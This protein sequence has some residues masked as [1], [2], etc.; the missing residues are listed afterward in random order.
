[1]ICC[2]VGDAIFTNSMTMT[3]TKW[4]FFGLTKAFEFTR[5]AQIPKF[6]CFPCDL[7]GI[8]WQKMRRFAPVL[9]WW[10]IA[11]QRRQPKLVIDLQ[12][13][14]HVWSIRCS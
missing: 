12:S 11:P 1:M 2:V 14:F 7:L 4:S 13:S 5:S 6:P 10:I 3:M 9:E 8:F